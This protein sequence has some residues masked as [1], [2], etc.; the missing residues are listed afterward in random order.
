MQLPPH[1]SKYRL[2][3]IDDLIIL[4]MIGAGYRHVDMVHV[5]R[6]TAPAICQRL[7]KYESIWPGFAERNHTGLNRPRIF[8]DDCKQ[9]CNLAKKMLESLNENFSITD[10]L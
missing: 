6:I 3:D 2:L 8:N 4:T 9:A 10:L 7:K 5:L 1:L